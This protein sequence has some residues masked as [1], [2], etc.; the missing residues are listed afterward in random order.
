MKTL[1]RQE[2]VEL[3]KKRMGKKT[4]RGF[5]EEIGLSAPYLS[6]VFRGNREPGPSILAVIGVEK[7]FKTTETTYTKVKP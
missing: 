1:T 7:V 3:L 4:L 6:D 5:G 2:V